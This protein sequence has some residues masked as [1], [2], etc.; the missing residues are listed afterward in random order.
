MGV[1]VLALEIVPELGDVQRFGKMASRDDD[2]IEFCGFAIRRF[3]GPLRRVPAGLKR[4]A[5]IRDRR[6]ETDA[7]AQVK[8][9]RV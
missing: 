7:A 4:R 9:I 5:D 1:D 2:R 8:M 3:H 6:V